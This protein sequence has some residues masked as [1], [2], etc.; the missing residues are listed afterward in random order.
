MRKRCWRAHETRLIA[1]IA[2]VF[3]AAGSG[4]AAESCQS[5]LRFIG[6][7]SIPAGTRIDGDTFGGIS[8]IDYDPRARLWYLVSD[9][10]S[11]HGPARFFTAAIRFDSQRVHSVTLRKTQHFKTSAFDAES[12]RVDGTGKG[13]FVAGEGDSA[14]GFGAWLRHIDVHGQLLAA[15][16]LPSLFTTTGQ[17]G[18]R[19]NRSI[20]GIAFAPDRR[21]LWIALETPLLQDG[22]TASVNQTSDVRLTRMTLSGEVL[23]QHVYRTDAA[24]EHAVGESS[25]NGI[26]EVLAL[27]ATELLVLE[28]SGVKS[29]DGNFRFHTRLYCADLAAATDVAAFDSLAG[30]SYRVAGKRL[31]MNFDTLPVS[32]GNL[33]AMGWGS[34]LDHGQRSLVFASDNNFFPDVP[35]QLLFFSVR[36]SEAGAH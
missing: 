4:H 3:I 2:G 28:R 8:G 13:L 21:S 20:E 24:S 23:A 36:P 10:R 29:R 27:S 11:E 33:E 12:L 19:P 17:R 18:P 15:V 34:P 22:P 5:E 14:N 30:A 32:A 31:L 6:A 26:S 1:A 25:D 16:P 9:D 35:T 7:N